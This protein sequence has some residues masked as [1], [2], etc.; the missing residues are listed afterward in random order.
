MKKSLAILLVLMMV[1]SFA[2]CGQKAVDPNAKDEGVL[3]HA[4][5]I[6]AADGSDVTIEG[7][8]TAK[9]Y[10]KDYG[11]CN[12]MIQDGNGAYYVYRMPCT[13]QD[14]AKLVVGQKVKVTGVRTAW[15]GENELK[16]GSA[17]YEI[18]DG[19]YTFEA[20][21]ITSLLPTDNLI[22]L[23]NM[24]VKVVG[25]TVAKAALYKWDGSG[26]RGDDL[27]LD[28]TVNDKPYTF[29]VESDLCGADTD[30]Y[31]AVE[32]LKEGQV[33][34]IEGYLYWYNGPQMWIE[35]VTVK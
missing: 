20:K 5:Y 29:V 24:K 4:E 14:D 32:G 2:A 9:M 7:F 10:A 27:Y 17:A 19:K 23:Q 31:K 35:T 1:L 30:T 11:N 21:D 16:E 34:D 33:I 26:D 15:S 6:A 22:D 28:I 25:A 18:V 3:S 13:D 12:L 8:I